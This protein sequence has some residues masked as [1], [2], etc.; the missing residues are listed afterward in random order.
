M[1]VGAF[2]GEDEPAVWYVKKGDGSGFVNTRMTA[3]AVMALFKM[4]GRAAV[5]CY[6]AL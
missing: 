1:H 6:S 4:A 5:P 2:R 3:Y